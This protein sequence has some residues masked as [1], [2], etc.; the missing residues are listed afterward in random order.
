MC[1]ES[2][3]EKKESKSSAQCGLELAVHCMQSL[4]GQ[5]I[6]NLIN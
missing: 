5:A 3:E 1:G 6:S 2:S 4:V